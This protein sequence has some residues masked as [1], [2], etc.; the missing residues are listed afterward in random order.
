[1]SVLCL[2][3]LL[4]APILPLHAGDSDPAHQREKRPVRGRAAWYA[5]CRTPTLHAASV[6]RP[7]RVH[8]RTVVRKA[9]YRSQLPHIRAPAGAYRWRSTG[10]P[11]LRAPHLVSW[12]MGEG[13][14]SR[15]Q[16][17]LA[18]TYGFLSCEQRVSLLS[19]PHKARLG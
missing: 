5:A 10:R 2:G 3:I 12:G 19:S 18:L 4:G 14:Q 9:I 1:M 8:Q 16:L 13:R 6:H 7:R 15:A 11:W 17:L